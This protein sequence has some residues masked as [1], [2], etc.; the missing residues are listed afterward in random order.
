MKKVIIAPDSFK[1]TMSAREVCRI[2]SEEVKKICPDAEVICIPMSDGGE[3]MSESYVSLIGGELRFKEVTGPLGW[4]VDAEYGI[5][6]DGTA[7]M[8]M[9]SCAGL[10]LMKGNLQPLHATTW[11]VGELMVHIAAQGCRKLLIGL[12]GSATND[13]GI[14]MADAV[15]YRFLD[16]DG[17][18]LAPYAWNLAR[19]QH[20]VPPGELP[21]LTVTAACDV[22]NPLCGPRG[23][24]AVFGPQKGLQPEQI[25]PHDG[26]MAHFAEVIK[27]ELGRD[28]KDI[29]GAGAAGG[30]GAGMLAFLNAELKPGIELLLDSVGFDAMLENADLVITGEGRLDG[31]SVAGKV[32]VGVARRAKAKG[33]SCIALCGCIG[34]EAEQVLS[35]GIDA[36]YASSDGSRSF[37]EVKKSCREDLAALAAGVLPKHLTNVQ[38]KKEESSDIIN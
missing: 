20:I 17:Q 22:N 25:G 36:Y 8:E 2:L 3:G 38:L 19:V 4:F 11:G 15:G 13:C 34:A 31:Q 30:L 16:G 29:P 9:A 18:Q 6:P 23:A 7:V 1:G 10:P 37:E 24:A 5:L 27:R 26:A 14:G 21:A 12:G 35:C 32:P 28:V 33:V